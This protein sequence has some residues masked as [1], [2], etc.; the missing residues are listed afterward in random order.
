MQKSKIQLLLYSSF[1]C[2]ALSACA[3]TNAGLDPMAYD[4]AQN[5]VLQATNA[6]KAVNVKDFSWPT[7]PY[8]DNYAHGGE[9]LG[10]SGYNVKIDKVLPG[11]NSYF[12]SQIGDVIHFD[13]D[14]ITLN[15]EG[16]KLLRLQA[17]WIAQHPHKLLIEGYADE[18]G[19]R[20]YNIALGA[21]RAS[22]VRE[23]LMQIGIPRATLKT[24]SYG[25]DRP[26]AVCGTER[27]W[28]Q[29]RRAKIVLR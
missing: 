13:L 8:D 12:T 10:N 21:K 22:A 25:K 26:V 29:N 20:A 27:C 17:Q 4:A 5:P 24:V 15:E 23:Y 14:S 6:E 9:N 1:M 3:R 2:V 28:S 11:D 16:K 19:T 7:N 18:R